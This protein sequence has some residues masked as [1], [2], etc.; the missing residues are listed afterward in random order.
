MEKGCF[1]FISDQYFDVFQDARLMTNKGM[2][3]GRPCFFAFQDASTGLYWLV[4]ISSQVEKYKK[5][6]AQ[7]MKKYRKCDTIVFGEVL[8]QERAFLIQN[9]CPVKARYIDALYMDKRAQLP[10]RV[11]GNLERLIIQKAKRVLALQRQGRQLIFPDVLMIEARL[12][13]EE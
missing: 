7:K 1:Y 13:E 10:V 5:Y 2:T 12:L 3:H 4:P 8:G 6:H 9:M 11:A